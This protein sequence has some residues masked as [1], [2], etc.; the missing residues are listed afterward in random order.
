M[1]LTSE[2]DV[3]TLT[4]HRPDK[5]NAIGP[6]MLAELDRLMAEIDVDPDVR[7]VISHRIR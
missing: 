6:D 1:V 5:L 2:D 4:L 3:A 7:V